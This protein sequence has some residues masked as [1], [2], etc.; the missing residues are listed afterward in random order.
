MSYQRGSVILRLSS[1]FPGAIISAVTWVLAYLIRS[2]VHARSTRSLDRL[3]W[4]PRELRSEKL[5]N[6]GG[7]K[8]S[9]I[10][11]VAKFK[12]EIFRMQAIEWAVAKLQGDNLLLSAGK[13]AVAK[14]QGDKSASESSM[15]LSYPWISGPLCFPE[16]QRCPTFLEV[17]SRSG[18]E[19]SSKFLKILGVVSPHLPVSKKFQR[20]CLVCK[21]D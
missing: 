17:S 4:Q 11:W 6:S 16:E 9:S 1:L 8:G 2:D 13:W 14:L 20:F 12:G 15:D 19:I 18:T 10:S 21:N 7:A 5:Q 3:R